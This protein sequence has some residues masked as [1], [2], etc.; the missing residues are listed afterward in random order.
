MFFIHNTNLIIIF[1]NNIIYT[2]KNTKN[3]TKI[4]YSIIFVNSSTVI[5]VSQRHIIQ[6]ITPTNAIKST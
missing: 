2:I 6:T 5:E 1:Y 3:N 4:I